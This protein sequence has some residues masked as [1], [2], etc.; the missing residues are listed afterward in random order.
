MDEMLPFS[1]NENV[2]GCMVDVLYIFSKFCYVFPS[3][4]FEYNIF[5]VSVVPTGKFKNGGLHC[6]IECD[7]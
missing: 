3:C 6:T 5:I 7:A 1:Y 2:W 4:N